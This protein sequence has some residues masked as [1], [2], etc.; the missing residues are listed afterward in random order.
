MA[1]RSPGEAKVNLSETA[2]ASS[3]KT[4][5]LERQG[6]MSKG[7]TWLMVLIAALVGIVF[8]LA[9]F[10]AYSWIRLPFPGFVV[11]Q[12]LVVSNYGGEGWSGRSQGLNYPQKI[13][14]INGRS[15]S[16]P[17]EFISVL[18]SLPRGDE[19]T[20]TAIMPDGTPKTY[21]GVLLTSFPSV[22]LMR[23]FWIPY[24]VGLAFYVL[25]IWVFYVRPQSPSGRAFAYF[26]L[27]AAVVNGLFFDLITTHHGT[28]IWFL[29]L[30]QLGSAL[31]YLGLL[32]PEQWTPPWRLNWVR[33][34]PFLVS[35]VLAVWG[36]LVLYDAGRPWTYV[37]SWRLS[38]IYTAFGIIFFLGVML[39]RLRVTTAPLVRQQ[40][41]VILGGSIAAFIPIL[42][43]LI[44]PVFG[45]D[46]PFITLL[47]L[48]FLLLF[49]ISISVAIL[50]YRLWD[51]DLL[52]NRTL[53][54]GVLTLLLGALYISVVIL[55]QGLF[56]RLTG[57]NSPAAVALSTLLIAVVFNPV[58]QRTQL[59]IDHRFFRRKYETAHSMTMLSNALRQEVSLERLTDKLLGVVEEILHPV[60]VTL[61]SLQ[62]GDP[63]PY[64]D[65]A[66]D[67]PLRQLMLET[68]DLLEIGDEI[69]DSQ[70][71]NRLQAG[72]VKVVVPLVSQG[73]IVG[74]LALGEPRGGPYYSYNDR[75]LLGLIAS[76]AAPALRI[77]Q[78]VHLQEVEAQERQ[79]IDD[80]LKVA[81]FIQQMLL[82]KMMPDLPGWMIAGYY[83]PAQAV[84]GDFFDFIQFEDGSLG[85]VIGD[86]TGHGIP[87]ALEMAAARSLI[88]GI[89]M[90]LVS[91]G[92]VLHK[93]NELLIPNTPKAMFVT[94]L[95]ATLQPETG[96]I[97]F[98]NA[99]HPLP[100]WLTEGDV[101]ELRARGMP[102]GLMPDMLYEEH[103]V[104]LQPGDCVVL[105]SD[106]LI[107]AHDRNK[108]MYGVPRLK[109][110]LCGFDQH[111]AL[112]GSLLS[113]WRAFNGEGEE[114]EDDMTLVTIHRVNHVDPRD[115]A[116]SDGAN[117]G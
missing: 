3:E 45:I 58:R 40:M 5:S 61:Y 84:G 76:H 15:V 67:D 80:E 53:V 8:I 14:T 93:V 33:Y 9:P 111:S 110:F 39:Y 10:W 105:Y 91:P 32:F 83:Q 101:Q 87:A 21:T 2:R 75:Q 92:K 102:L 116:R 108:M 107:E 34:L 106:G 72:G 100:A 17:V 73:E 46:L 60:H 90:Q 24:L 37:S 18:S 52:V 42:F 97:R 69:Q 48:P 98:A 44:A 27:M 51:I 31:G 7:T 71:L 77:A 28:L 113:E 54:Y 6:S 23:L 50:R 68:R 55:L 74:V 1:S 62:A 109:Q 41:W 35:T 114:Q 20:V 59:V 103:E 104:T 64:L 57:Q 36:L 16:A 11:E 112:I 38:F 89:A 95:Y 78:L 66:S 115:Q 70:G 65:I 85:I 117:P 19:L 79:H 26:S 25:G 22:D 86:A 47:F 12:T 13:T 43:W 30:T 94:C 4:Y 81:R 88:R 99:G 63:N 29:A 56:I 49:P 82:P 96:H